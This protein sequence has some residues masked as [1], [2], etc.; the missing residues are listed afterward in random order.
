MNIRNYF[1]KFARDS[2]LRHNPLYKYVAFPAQAEQKLRGSH[3]R[4]AFET[5]FQLQQTGTSVKKSATKALFSE[6]PGCA[7]V[8]YN[9]RKPI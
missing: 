3:T 6:K 9:Y 8:R 7:E 4:Y 2:I 1:F 5:S